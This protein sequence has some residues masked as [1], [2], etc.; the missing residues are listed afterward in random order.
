MIKTGGL[1]MKSIFTLGIF[2][3]LFSA[4]T[5]A[6]PPATVPG[7]AVGKP[8]FPLFSFPDRSNGETAIGR[9]GAN[10]PEVAAWYDLSP[11]EFTRTLRKDHSAWIDRKGHLLYIDTFAE[12]AQASEIEAPLAASFPLENTFT[13]HSR[14][15]AKRVIY[16]DFDG[17]VTTGT[18]WNSSTDTIVSPAYTLDGDPA[19][20]NTELENIQDMWRQVSED[21]APFDVDV[22]T[23]EPGAAAI[24]R[25]SNDDEYYGT[26][27]VI[28][29]D[30]FDGCGCGGFAYIG[31]F[32]NVGGYHKP[33]FVFNSSLVGAGEAITHEVGHNLGL[34]HDGTS[35]VGYYEGHGSGA[36]GWAPIMGV[37]YYEKLVQWSRGEYTDA[38]NSEDDLVLIQNNGATLAA[39]DHGDSRSSAASLAVSS[40]G[41]TA[42]LSGSGTIGRRDDVDVFSFI[43]GAGI[44]SLNIDPAPFSPNLDILAQLY[45]S[46]GTL[47]DS[48]NPTESLPAA[49]S[50]SLAAGEYFLYVDGVGKGSVT[51]TGYSGYGSL[52]RYSVS[53]TV[54]DASGLASPIAVAS[55]MDPSYSPDIPG[56]EIGFDGS[57]SG[58][59]DG[60]DSDLTFD[61]DFGDGE[62]A[63]G[64]API[65]AFAT[66]GTHT[67]TLT[68]TD[69]DS[70]TG[71]DTL[72]V[73]VLEGPPPPIV[74]Q[75]ATGELFVAGTVSGS[76]LDTHNLG[77]AAQFITE[78]ESGGRK[79]NRYSYLEHVWLFNVQPGDAVSLVVSGSQS[80]SSDGDQMRI[81]YKI[82]S[83]SG[84]Q[85]PVIFLN[86]A[87]AEHIYPLPANTS[88]EV[89]VRLTDSDRSAG[90]RSRDTATIDQIYIRTE[91]SDGGVLVAM[92]TWGAVSA[93]KNSAELIW[94]DNSN[95]ED[96]FRLEQSLDGL[97]WGYLSSPTADSIT[98]T[99]SVLSANTTY[100]YRIQAY[101]D[102]TESAW[103]TTSVKT[104]DDNQ[105][106]LTLAANGYKV[107][108]RQKVDLSWS[109]DTGAVNIYRDGEIVGSELAGSSSS[110]DDIGKKGGGTYLY[111]IC[112]TASPGTCSTE[113]V[114][115]F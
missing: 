100:H 34:R 94:S 23:E 22:T 26:R 89:R 82:P 79:P 104:L 1:S 33:A 74:D 11:A 71:N 37:G 25:S 61:W 64:V 111:K 91:N 107:K 96:G 92:P 62:T 84:Y 49:L 5:A 41:S 101:N 48:S 97:S 69:V 58:D 14:P 38:N 46:S 54:P 28:T 77:G 99:D 44:Y 19:F 75:F 78:R 8:D 55:F 30:N 72:D 93:T 24:N 12:P 45:D 87:T 52:G 43:S 115:V 95:N 102:V 105:T 85:D 65:H 36:T 56:T 35:S 21:Y 9:L 60:A 66:S 86:N 112:L 57:Q 31:V 81:S 3:T 17:H 15:G 13:L 32:D 110:T 108:G 40:D 88:G 6:A 18:V 4:T 80:G 7:K 103:S 10:L 106:T 59:P 83:Q 113:A 42:T 39:D 68:V 50:G 47:V 29:K 90:N 63:T 114:V 2:L 27:V 70:L 53:G 109:A 76:Y 73:L 16:L 51:G 98:Y 20:S 67:V